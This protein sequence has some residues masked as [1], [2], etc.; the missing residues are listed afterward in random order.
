MILQRSPAKVY[1]TNLF[2]NCPGAPAKEPRYA[3]AYR[4]QNHAPAEE[5]IK[6]LP[7]KS[8][9]Q[10]PRSSCRGAWI[11]SCLQMTKQCSSSRGAHQRFTKQSC[12]AIAHEL[13]QRSLDMLRLADCKTMLLQRSQWIFYQTK[14]FSNC[15]EIPAE[16]SRYGLADTWQNHAPS[17]E[18]IIGL[19]NKAV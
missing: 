18:A 3:H 5:P 14:L 15:L 16:E 4:L 11:C 6:G 13:L 8:V 9:Q 17:G 7:N 10:L 2:S 1:Q 12:L 19:P